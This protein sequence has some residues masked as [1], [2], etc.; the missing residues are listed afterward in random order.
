M[1]KDLKIYDTEKGKKK[2]FE[3]LSPGYVRMYCCGPTVYDYLHIGN[4]R[5]AVFFNFVR[6]WLE[7][8]G[9]KVDYVYNFT[10]IDDKILNR[11]KEESLSPQKLAEKYILEF[12]KDYQN[13]KLKSPT[14]HPRAT[15]TLKEIIRLIEK[16]IKKNKAYEVDGNVFYSISSFKEYGQLS[17][18]NT[19]ELLS[20]TR[21]ENE[22][23]KK[24]PLDFALWKKTKK[25]ET[26][27]F[28]SPWGKGRPGWHIECTA[29]IHKFL[30]E[31]IDIHGGGSDLIF[32]HH[33]N[34]IAQSSGLTGKKYVR[35]WMHNNMIVTEGN[36]MSKSL[37]NMISMRSFLK[38]YPAELFKFLILSCHYRSPLQF[39][40]KTLEQAL[41]SLLKLYS[42]FVEADKIKKSTQKL[43]ANGTSKNLKTFKQKLQSAKQ[44]I[45]EAF[46]DDFATPK[47][48][49]V[50]FSLFHLFKKEIQ[51][52]HNPSKIQIAQEY[53][54]FF[55]RYGKPL[56]LFQENPSLFF[57]T[58]EDKFL[59][60]KD[61]KRKQIDQIVQER[62][63]ARQKKNFKKSDA[64]RKQ[65]DLW[66][67]EV[68]DTSE[69]SEWHLRLSKFID[70]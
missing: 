31:E 15:Q 57:K 36:K 44:D 6:N 1:K 22:P 65:L 2:L 39:S 35:F 3:S 17:N 48:F 41:V 34:E 10:D 26:W 25:K 61:I 60:Q 51:D 70:L 30:G 11:S 58:L 4:F 66:N 24:N 68:K 42:S 55:K 32:P 19:E 37:G 59:E 63:L 49:A 28:E 14:H 53:L 43:L 40:K 7:F 8:L 16:L 62:N 64:L 67:I 46:N 12:K 29:M 54:S 18:R 56:S 38:N 47:A 45:Q 13:L 21:V 5:G 27:Y 20:E 9:Y 33:E 23:G 50:F 52:K 69:G